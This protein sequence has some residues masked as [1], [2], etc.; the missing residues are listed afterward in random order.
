MIDATMAAGNGFG[1]SQDSLAFILGMCAV[2][3]R[4]RARR[5]IGG[6]RCGRAI[7]RPCGIFFI[8]VFYLRLQWSAAGVRLT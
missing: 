1:R 5:W 6:R 4:E 7:A 2:M 8:P 3:A